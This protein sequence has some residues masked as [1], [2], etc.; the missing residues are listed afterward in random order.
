MRQMLDTVQASL[1][2]TEV[3]FSE[4][5]Q[6]R[7]DLR[8]SL[9]RAEAAV[10]VL[11]DHLERSRSVNASLETSHAFLK[12]EYMRLRADLE[13]KLRKRNREMSGMREVRDLMEAEQTQGRRRR[14]SRRATGEGSSRDMLR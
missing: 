5:V 12:E 9:D 6:L 13:R 1:L 8:R 10:R 11:T 14:V 7:N 3:E 4:A 2:T